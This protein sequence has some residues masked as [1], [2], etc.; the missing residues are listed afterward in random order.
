MI[1][2][3]FLEIKHSKHALSKT[4]KKNCKPYEKPRQQQSHKLL[5][6]SLF[7]FHTN[8]GI[9][10]KGKSFLPSAILSASYL[11]LKRIICLHHFRQI[12][13][14]CRSYF[15]RLYLGSTA[16]AITNFKLCFYSRRFSLLF[17]VLHSGTNSLNT[18][19]ICSSWHCLM[20]IK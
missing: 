19:T 20:F 5:K 9:K 7:S 16:T 1:E 4:S 14:F 11:L 13:C 3:N 8:D 15:I 10:I 2:N 6:Y 12:F 18:D 17:V